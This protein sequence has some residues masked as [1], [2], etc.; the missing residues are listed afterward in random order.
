MSECWGVRRALPRRDAAQSIRIIIAD[1]H[2][3]S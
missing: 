3:W 1:N 2:E